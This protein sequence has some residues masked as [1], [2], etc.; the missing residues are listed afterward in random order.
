MAET[1]VCKTISSITEKTKFDDTFFDWSE[2]LEDELVQKEKDSNIE[3][4]TAS[5]T[6]LK[7]EIEQLEAIRKY[8]GE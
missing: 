7:I 1:D 3:A 4:I 8:T 6:N 2:E 5:I